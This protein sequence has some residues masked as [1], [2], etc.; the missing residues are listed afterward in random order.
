MDI[1]YMTDAKCLA[2]LFLFISRLILN[3]AAVRL[4][5]DPCS[6]YSDNSLEIK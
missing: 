1:S 2:F 6:E 3:F 5:D 4:I